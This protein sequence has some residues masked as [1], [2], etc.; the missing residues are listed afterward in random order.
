MFCPACG[1]AL[2]EETVYCHKCGRKITPLEPSPSQQIQV[3]PPLPQ[4]PP[5]NDTELAAAL[6]RESVQSDMCLICW[7]DDNLVHIDF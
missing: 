3:L 5:R 1:V 6:R 7:A 2:Y 4:M